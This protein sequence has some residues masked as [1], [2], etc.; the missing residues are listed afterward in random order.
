M[1]ITK[2]KNG[3]KALSEA[4]RARGER[5]GFVP[6][7]GALHEG[8]ASL[9]RRA[10]RE[11][12]RVAI[13]IFVNPLQFGPGEDFSRYP[14]TL[15]S[16]AR[17]C[18]KLG[19]DVLYHPSAKEIYSERFNTSVSVP[20]LSESLC[21]KFR[22][23]HFSGVATVVLKLLETV[24]PHLAYF[25]EKDFQQL[26]VITRM[27]LDLDLPVQIVGCPTLRDRDGLALSSRNRYLNP[28]DRRQA[29][30]LPAALN[31]GKLAAREP[32]MTPAKL[33]RGVLS[34]I[35][36]IPGVRVDYVEIADPVTLMFPKRLKGRFRLLAAIRIRN[37][38][39]IDNLAFS[40]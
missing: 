18:R 21:G 25:G 7:M 30:K 29:L 9:I 1:K 15:R 11:N 37:T 23:G 22:P 26:A 19:V 33:R 10:R 38:R 16:D 35:K 5:I 12:D 31:W 2:T 3:M 13:S 27:A 39:L 24:A 40:C 20:K 17:L 4:W 14:R 28:A 32:G 36:K 34:R 8:H 6:T